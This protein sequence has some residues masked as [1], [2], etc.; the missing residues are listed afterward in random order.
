MQLEKG[1]NIKIHGWE[2]Y[3]MW[4]RRW[5]W[6]AHVSLTTRNIS[7]LCKSDKKV[8]PQKLS[9]KNKELIKLQA[10]SIK[11]MIFFSLRKKVIWFWRIYQSYW[12]LNANDC[13]VNAE[14][15]WPID[16][17]FWVIVQ[18]QNHLLMNYLSPYLQ[19]FR[20]VNSCA[21]QI[22]PNQTI[23]KEKYWIQKFSCYNILK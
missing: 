16:A 21:L 7:I 12:T 18:H 23:I 11:D 2:K 22:L 8:T 17:M 1:K 4:A 3:N 9:R 13:C 14:Y 6:L 15:T 19:M 5:I 20:K 10:T